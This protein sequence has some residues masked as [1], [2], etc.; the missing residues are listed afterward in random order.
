MAVHVLV[1]PGVFAS[2]LSSVSA[3]VLG[4]LCSRTISKLDAD[5]EGGGW[6]GCSAGTGVASK[7][8]HR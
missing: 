2:H 3:A 8:H 4:F 6:V 1:F 7:F 5:Q